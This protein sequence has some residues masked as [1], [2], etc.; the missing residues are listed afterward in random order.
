MKLPVLP[1]TVATQITAKMDWRNG[2]KALVA[3]A[4]S[5][6]PLRVL[7]SWPGH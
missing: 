4:G 7:P 1:I 3:L 5:A 6:A 2:A